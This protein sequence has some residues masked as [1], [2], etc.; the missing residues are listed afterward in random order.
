MEEDDGK[1]LKPQSV[2]A[3]GAEAYSD[4][5]AMRDGGS[6]DIIL[7]ISFQDHQ[8]RPNDRRKEEGKKWGGKGRAQLDS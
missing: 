7:I 3:V 4:K 1:G 8:T 2:V 5:K 6:H